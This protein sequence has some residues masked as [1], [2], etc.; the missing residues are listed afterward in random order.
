MSHVPFRLYSDGGNR[1]G[2]GSCYRSLYNELRL[3]AFRRESG[4][5]PSGFFLNSR[6]S[7]RL[8]RDPQSQFCFVQMGTTEAS[9]IGSA[10]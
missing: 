3:L 8:Y 7:N 5:D 2:V 9:A 1:R 6:S 4:R 10:V